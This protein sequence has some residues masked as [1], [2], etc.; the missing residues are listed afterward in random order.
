MQSKEPPRLF[1]M[2]QLIKIFQAMK[3]PGPKDVAGCMELKENILLN[4]QHTFS[5][6]SQ[7]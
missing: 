2:G 7:Q 5:F 4:T 6:G 1:E 3:A